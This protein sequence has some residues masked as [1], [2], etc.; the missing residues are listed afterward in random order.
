MNKRRIVFVLAL[1][2]ISAPFLVQGAE[3]NRSIDQI[4][5]EIQTKKQ[6][7]DA[8][9]QQ[10]ANYKTYQSRQWQ[11]QPLV[12]SGVGGEKITPHNPAVKSNEKEGNNQSDE[13]DRKGPNFFA[14]RLKGQASNSPEHSG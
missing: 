6:R 3:D 1:L 13:V 8:L 5:K 12:T 7:I 11:P 4:N 10:I 2:L 9:Q 14:C